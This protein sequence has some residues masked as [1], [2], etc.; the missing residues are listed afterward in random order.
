MKLLKK[1]VIVYGGLGLTIAEGPVRAAQTR[2][3]CT[4]CSAKGDKKIREPNRY[5]RYAA[6]EF[7]A[8]APKYPLR[9]NRWYDCLIVVDA[10]VPILAG[11]WLC[12]TI[13]LI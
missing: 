5:P 10:P 6:Y 12:L 11:K 2:V 4:D 1:R 7:H 13:A 9:E 8:S 3:C